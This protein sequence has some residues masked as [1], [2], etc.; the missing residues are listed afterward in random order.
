MVVNKV[1][2]KKMILNKAAIIERVSPGVFLCLIVAWIYASNVCAEVM[3][4]DCTQQQKELNEELLGLELQFSNCKSAKQQEMDN[5]NDKRNRYRKLLVWVGSSKFAVQLQSTV[6]AIRER[7]VLLTPKA[8]KAAKCLST[9]SNLVI[10]GKEP[11][12]SKTCEALL[13]KGRGKLDRLT[14]ELG[15][16]RACGLANIGNGYNKSPVEIL[17]A[18]E[19]DA[20]ILREALYNEL[21]NQREADRFAAFNQWQITRDIFIA[22]ITDK[23]IE[24]PKSAKLNVM[25]QQLEKKLESSDAPNESTKKVIEVYRQIAATLQSKSSARMSEAKQLLEKFRQAI[26]E[27]SDSRDSM[28]YTGFNDATDLEQSFNTMMRQEINTLVTVIRT[29]VDRYEKLHRL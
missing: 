6:D 18:Q 19:K 23:T 28:R 14:K 13:V 29:A 16:C 20:R 25:L 15:R 4:S 10:E 17:V 7:D 22:Y 5:F 1:L 2:L 24:M 3:T 27:F 21:V 26:P 8:E 11:V 9:L 12:E